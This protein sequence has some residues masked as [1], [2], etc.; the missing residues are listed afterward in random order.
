MNDVFVLKKV[1]IGIVMGLGIV[2]VK[3]VLEMVLADDNFFIIVVV[4]EEG[5]VIYN[6]M[7]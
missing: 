2:V 6:N 1:E 4:V 7:K 5:R 3:L